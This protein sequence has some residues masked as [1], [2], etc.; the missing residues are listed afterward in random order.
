MKNERRNG[1]GSA[2]VEGVAGLWVVILAV[3]GGVL[4]VVGLGTSINYQQKINHVA[5]VAAR[6]AANQP[7]GTAD[8]N[9]PT[10]AVIRDMLDAC[11]IP[12][13]NFHLSVTPATVGGNAGAK[14]D[15]SVNSLALPG[16]GTLL[17]AVVSLSSSAVAPRDAYIPDG[18]LFLSC[19]KTNNTANSANT[20]IAIPTYGRYTTSSHTLNSISEV[21]NLGSA[22]F[23]RTFTNN[24]YL[25]FPGGGFNCS[26]NGGAT[27]FS[28][29]DYET[30]SSHFPPPADYPGTA[31]SQ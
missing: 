22:L 31:M 26:L 21:G 12:N 3:V 1:R 4:L 15:I 18:V 29:F 2:I 25:S 19:R 24:Y 7:L 20:S 30:S 11:G 27:K 28:F 10:C 16:N 17:P 9:T 6:F 13:A 5:S 8:L 23:P 14:V